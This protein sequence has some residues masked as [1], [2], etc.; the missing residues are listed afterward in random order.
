ML[1]KFFKNVTFKNKHHNKM[2]YNLAECL[3]H[4]EEQ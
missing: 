2:I 1:F 4:C 3:N